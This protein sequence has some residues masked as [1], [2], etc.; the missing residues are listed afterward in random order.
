MARRKYCSLECRQR[1]RYHLNL[2]TGLLKALQ[3]HYATFYFTD[4][5]I[6]LD[7]L[8]YGS[9]DLYSFIYPRTR[10]KKPVDD[11]TTM[12]NLLGNAWWAEKRRTNKRYLATQ[13]LLEI[14]QHRQPH[15]G[16]V[17][18]LVAREPTRVAGS[19]AFLRLT[20]S[21]LVSSQLHRKIKSAFRRQ[22]MRYHPDQ[23]GDAVLFRKLQEAYEQLVHWADNPTFTS[24]RGFPDKWFYDGS[25]NRW[26]QPTPIRPPIY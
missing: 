20:R 1:L 22:A 25:T 13:H 26:I 9:Q 2:R 18:P 24:R 5:K 12:A 16:T 19:L 8:P 15:S 21:D 3:T 7:V 6:V 11:Y 17:R 4:Y 10:G 14:A 23:G